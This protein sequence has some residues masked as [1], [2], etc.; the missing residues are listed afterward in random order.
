MNNFVRFKLKMLI[1]LTFCVFMTFSMLIYVM[2][3]TEKCD[4][5]SN[6]MCIHVS[7]NP[8]LKATYVFYK[9]RDNTGFMSNQ[10]IKPSISPLSKFQEIFTTERILNET[11]EKK[12]MF[13][14]YSYDKFKTTNSSMNETNLKILR[15]NLDGEYENK[16]GQ[17]EMKDEHDNFNNLGIKKIQGENSSWEKIYEK[18]YKNLE[19]ICSK[20][21]DSKRLL[22]TKKMKLNHVLIDEKHKILYCYVPKVACTNWKRIFLVLTGKAENFSQVINLPASQIHNK[23]LFKSLQNYS[24]TEILNMTNEY[25]KFIF[26]RHPFERLLSA[27]RNKLEQHY[28]SSK[29]F[30]ARFGKYII[31]NFRKNPTNVSLA[32][33]DDVTFSEFVNYIVSSDP[34]RYN[35][36][37]QRMTD[38]CHPCLIKYDFIGK[39]EN[40]IQDSNFLLKSFGTSLKF[41]KL[42]K[43]STTASNLAKYY[44]TLERKTILK[45]YRIYEMDFRL[46]DYDVSII[47]KS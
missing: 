46:F 20:Y 21:F 26:V 30:Q 40:I 13:N 19:N 28:D 31:K 29:Y 11:I 47:D 36:H 16:E 45:L 1:V 3:M 23:N 42:S 6:E 10:M 44:G 7:K 17:I 35:E 18:R 32:K 43:P 2:K 37:W 14:N 39:Y 33:G 5:A 15:N 24:V 8:F 25:T 41:P 38:L 34:N 22:K 4:D 27:Y 9:I 12:T